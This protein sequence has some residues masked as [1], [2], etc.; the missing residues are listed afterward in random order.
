[1]VQEEEEA[2]RSVGFGFGGKPRRA[3]RLI[4]AACGICVFLLTG[5]RQSPP[6]TPVSIETWNP[7]S[8][9]FRWSR[10]EVKLPPRL[11]Y[12]VAQGAKPYRAQ[13][14]SRDWS[15]S[16]DV[17][18]EDPGLSPSCTTEA[19][20]SVTDGNL[21]EKL[22]AGGRVWIGKRAPQK[23]DGGH[24]LG[25]VTVFSDPG[26]TTFFVFSTRGPE[27]SAIIDSIAGSFRPRH[28]ADPSR[29]R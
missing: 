12:H 27:G 13:F 21:E 17:I 5:C 18:S 26:C 22:V 4:A 10:G 2:M 7:K 16:I 15:L 3:P 28:P 20:K 6:E 24:P 8:G 1:M 11:R 19:F 23:Y 9:T 14:I 29:A 25:L